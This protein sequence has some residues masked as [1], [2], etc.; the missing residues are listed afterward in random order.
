M[1]VLGTSEAN[2]DLAENVTEVVIAYIARQ[3][4]FELAGKEEFQSRLGVDSE[5]RGQACLESLSCLSRAAVSLGV[6]RIVS[7]S[8]GTRGKQF[9]FSLALNNVES[10]QVENRVFR[11]IEGDVGLLIK[12]VEQGI[13]EL[14]KPRV[15]PGRV[16]VKSVPAGARVSIDNAYLGV[17]PLISGTLLPGAHKVRVEADNRFSWVSK[18]EVMPGQDLGINLTENN[19]PLRSRRP[20]RVAYTTGVMGVAALAAGGFFG[21]LSQTNTSGNTRADAQSDFNERKDFATYANVSLISGGAL[22]LISLATF[23]LYRDDIFGR[24]EEDVDLK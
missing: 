5:L 9:L 19:L 4:S 21:V 14:F 6:R 11:L 16:E 15:E 13:S 7:G 20:G 17:T 23:V 1:L 2:A 8:V 12:A 18:V 24:D 10:G 3:G 22:A